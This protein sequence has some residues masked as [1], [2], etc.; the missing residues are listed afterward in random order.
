[1]FRA[2][3]EGG[4]ALSRGRGPLGEVN[5]SFLRAQAKNLSPPE[6]RLAGWRFPSTGASENSGPIW[7][8]PGAPHTATAHSGEDRLVWPGPLRSE[9]SLLRGGLREG[10]A[11]L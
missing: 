9:L 7:G 5:T 4:A 11:H 1:M 10:E 3:A 6:V 8:P 2:G